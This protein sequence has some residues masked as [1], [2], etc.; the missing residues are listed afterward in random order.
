MNQKQDEGTV[1][2]RPI[3]KTS[4][5]SYLKKVGSL[6]ASKASNNAQCR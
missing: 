2:I 5:D 4:I 3:A 6:D 1:G